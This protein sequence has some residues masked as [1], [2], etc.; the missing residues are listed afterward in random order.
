ASD[1]IFNQTPLEVFG[2]QNTTGAQAQFDIMINL[3]AG[4]AP[5]EMKFVNYGANSYGDTNFGTFATN[6]A[7]VGSHPGIANAMAV[8]AVPFFNQRT[9]EGFTSVGPVTFLF[10]AS[11]NHL[12]SPLVVPKPDMMAPDGVSTTFFQPPGN[13]GIN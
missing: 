13:I 8:G 10:D 12:A 9:P 11:G 6:S 5:G 4:A 2:F 1:N 7:T 3:F